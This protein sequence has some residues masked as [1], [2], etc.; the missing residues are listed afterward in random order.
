MSCACATTP[1]S[2]AV[3][4]AG[5]GTID[6]GCPTATVNCGYVLDP[7]TG[8]LVPA[9]GVCAPGLGNVPVSEAEY[10]SSIGVCEQG[11]I[12]EARRISHE[13]G[14]RPYRV[15]LLWTERDNR[16]R[17]KPF[18]AIELIP[19][20]ISTTNGVARTLSESGMDRIGTIQLSEIS[21]A[22]V[23][24]LDLLGKIDGQ[25]P[26]PNIEFFYEVSRQ[27]RCATGISSG[28]PYR[29]VPSV[30]PYFDAE[31]YEWTISLM[32]QNINR[33]DLGDPTA[34]ADR[35]ETFRSGRRR[36]PSLRL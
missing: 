31:N 30:E 21:P 1:C 3:S 29:F 26:G 8:T 22:Q 9:P 13:L 4:V 14:F 18:K 17:A 7:V 23:E 16:Q 10:Q 12:D 35:D 15:M 36:K 27:R 28:P 34:P 11:T 24:Y 33:S 25:D 32:D 2:C 5:C 20:K 6:L 19:V